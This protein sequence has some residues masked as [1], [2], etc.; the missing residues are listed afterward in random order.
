MRDMR[1]CFSI[2]DRVSLI[3]RVLGVLDHPRRLESPYLRSE[4]HIVRNTSPIEVQVVEPKDQRQMAQC[5]V[6]FCLTDR[7]HVGKEPFEDHLNTNI[8]P[9]WT[10]MKIVRVGTHQTLVQ[11]RGVE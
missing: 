5:L 4:V 1:S 8:S 10:N 2:G 7:C 11:T 9:N 6:L 3:E